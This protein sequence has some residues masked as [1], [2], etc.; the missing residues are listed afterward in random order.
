MEE[1]T[2]LNERRT[3]L[4]KMNTFL[5]RAGEMIVCATYMRRCFGHLLISQMDKDLG[6][7]SLVV[8][9]ILSFVN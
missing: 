6:T 4:E 9:G 2:M 3:G 7:P 8:G 5:L 1:Q